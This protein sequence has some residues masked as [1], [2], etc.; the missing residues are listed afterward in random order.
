MLGLLDRN[1]VVPNELNKTWAAIRSNSI[2]ES[3][4]PEMI[5]PIIDSGQ[6]MFLAKSGQLYIKRYF[7][8]QLS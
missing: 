5:S 7:G 2:G 6:G 1:A 4:V 8:I 3:M